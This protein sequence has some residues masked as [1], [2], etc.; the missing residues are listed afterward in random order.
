[1]MCGRVFCSYLRCS[2]LVDARCERDDCAFPA[3]CNDL[4]W[5]WIYGPQVHISCIAWIC[6]G[7]LWH[8]YEWSPRPYLGTLWWDI[9]F[10]WRDR[11]GTHDKKSLCTEICVWP[12]RR[13]RKS[14]ISMHQIGTKQWR[15]EF[16]IWA[17]A[18]QIRMEMHVQFS[19]AFFCLVS[20]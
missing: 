8:H 1:M 13:T 3:Q 16:A 9:A 14:K 5:R 7:M 6:S 4:L 15:N 17:A 2:S 10:A 12:S 11:R 20:V 19:C 18:I